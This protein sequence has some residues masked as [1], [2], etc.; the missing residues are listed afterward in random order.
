VYT[1]ASPSSA[2]PG[3][4]IHYGVTLGIEDESG[5]DGSGGGAKMALPQAVTQ[6][7]DRRSAGPVFGG[8][9]LSAAEQAHTEKRKEIRGDFAFGCVLRFAGF[10]Q[11]GAVV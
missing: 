9:K 7:G 10:A 4:A 3:G 5:S 2:K 8:Q 11:G 1:S 6:D